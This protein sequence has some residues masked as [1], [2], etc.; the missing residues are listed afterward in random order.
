MDKQ[1]VKQAM[2]RL[3][4]CVVVPTYNNASTVGGVLESIGE[5][6][7]DVIV[8]NDGSPDATAGLLEGWKDKVTVIGYRPNR[9]KG[10]ALR[11]GFAEAAA[12]GFRYAVSI[13]SDGQHMASDLHKFVEQIESR[14]GALLV[15]S[16]DLRQE[17]MPGGNSFANRFSNFWFHLHTFR[18][19]PDT[20]SGYRLYPLGAV[21]GMR[22]FTGR[23]EAELEMLVRAAWKGVDI[24]PVPIE[25]YY[26][27]PGERVSSFRRGRD[28]LRI[29]LLNAALTFGA[30]FYG[31]WAIAWHKTFR[32]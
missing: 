12:R 1:A 26:A 8:V 31:W 2:G 9:G 3:G 14:P 32:R 16:R 10:Y 20:Q 22:I 19:L 5:Y 27:P 6:C 15:G 29:S 4:I 17:N 7:D 30:F 21:N 18:R 24:V 23:Y 11:R 13:D 28:F 25:V